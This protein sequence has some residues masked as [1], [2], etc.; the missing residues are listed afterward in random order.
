M[1]R[2]EITVHMTPPPEDVVAVY[3]RRG[4]T[5]PAL[6]G[7]YPPA[8]TWPYLPRYVHR[9]YAKAFGYYWLPCVLCRLHHG[10]H[11][12]SES[13]PDP[14]RGPNAGVAICPVCTAERNGG[15]P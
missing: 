1:S 12:I 4:I 5:P 13:I 6:A 3:R 8:A 15:T 2:H 11:E 7:P 9:L 14:T 10:G